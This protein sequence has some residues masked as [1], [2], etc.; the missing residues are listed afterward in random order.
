[1]KTKSPNMFSILIE[2]IMRVNGT[3]TFVH[4]RISSTLRFLIV[5]NKLGK[6]IIIQKKVKNKK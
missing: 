1:M 4:E 5:K 3:L 2:I 6:V